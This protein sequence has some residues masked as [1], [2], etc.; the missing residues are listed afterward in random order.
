M[1]VTL[2]YLA[3]V[4]W[5]VYLGG[6]IAME[7]VWRPV[8]PD[9]P[10]AQ[11]GVVC[12]RMGQRY[13]W[14]ALGGLGLLAASWGAATGGRLELAA[15]VGGGGATAGGWG[16]VLLVL[17]WAALVGLVLLMGILVHPLSHRRGPAGASDAVLAESRR[18]R[19]RAIR[20]MNVL[21]RTELA[22][23]LLTTLLLAAPGGPGLGR[24]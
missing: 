13:R 16:D 24:G 20:I 11:T 17:C 22:L 10:P 2:G 19:Q 1:R 3:T 14:V 12:Q 9:L 18:R 23:A 7:L 21:L 6:A 4:G 5:S 15:G 8:Q